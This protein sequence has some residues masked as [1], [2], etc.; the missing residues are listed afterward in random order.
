MLAAEAFN[1]K[2]ELV[3]GMLGV[4]L[5]CAISVSIGWRYGFQTMLWVIGSV[6]GIFIFLF[7]LLMWGIIRDVD[8]ILMGLIE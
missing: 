4:V 6:I 1:H 5:F 8:E 7:G 2:M 3:N